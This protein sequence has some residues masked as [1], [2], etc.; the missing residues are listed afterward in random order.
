MMKM[1]LGN[2]FRTLRMLLCCVLLL[3]YVLT[4]CLLRIVLCFVLSRRLLML[5]CVSTERI[6]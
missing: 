6:G 2:V 4:K 3:C 5:C 1:R